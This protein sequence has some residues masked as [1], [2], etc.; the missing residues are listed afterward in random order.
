MNYKEDDLLTTKRPVE[1][2]CK[3]VTKR[4]LVE[5][6]SFFFSTTD[7]CKCTYSLSSFI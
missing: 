5:L 7:K 6:K 2:V 4:T 3:E 1:R